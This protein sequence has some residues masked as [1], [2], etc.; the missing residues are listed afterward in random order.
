[1]TIY[2]DIV[3][4]ENFILNYIII[5]S[6]AII[7]KST[8]KHSR[9]IIASIIGSIFSITNYLIDMSFKL[10]FF[11]KILLSFLMIL[12]SFRSR[13]INKI[14]KQLI[15][16]YLVS[17]TYG[18][19]AFMLLF[20]ISPQNI[21]FA[22]N[23]FV[24]TYPIKITILAAAFGIIIIIII[25][26]ILKDRLSQN[27]MIC[28][29]EIFYD[30]KSKKIKAMLDTGNLLKE[31][32]SGAD[33]I[34]VEK[35]SLKEIIPEKVLENMVSIIDGKRLAEKNDYYNKIKIIPFSS[36]GN[37]NG[38]LVG[39]K[40]DYIKIYYENEI[41]RNDVLIGIYNGS[42]SKNNMF[43]SLIGLDIINK[44]GEDD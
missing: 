28:D 30:G 2:A 36:L 26:K 31:P 44:G 19:I 16:F 1:M 23:H 18:G 21:S 5:F 38:I 43:A 15:F 10:N 39:F 8:I 24:G 4:L 35:K 37:E 27:A 6:T 7:S 33:V 20:F 11:I 32:I 14:F 42:L 22:D 29:L 25:S 17:F 34:V 12:I 13:N 9:M 3:F 40:P 41:I